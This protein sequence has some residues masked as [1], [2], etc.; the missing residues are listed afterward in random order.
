M[1]LGLSSDREEAVVNDNEC[2]A[3]IPKR[4]Y[5]SCRGEHQQE[6]PKEHGYILGRHEGIDAWDGS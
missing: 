2:H 4:G 1:G 3:I 5:Q 6:A